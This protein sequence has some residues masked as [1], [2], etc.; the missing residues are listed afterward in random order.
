MSSNERYKIYQ[1]KSIDEVKRLF[2][3]PEASQDKWLFL[4][5][6][7]QSG[8][9]IS[10]E[11]LMQMYMSGDTYGDQKRVSLL[12]LLPAS[13]TMY[14]GYIS[15]PATDIPYLKSLVRS[16]MASVQRSQQGNGFPV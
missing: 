7:G 14:H 9:G 10:L 5:V 8:N 1:I 3:F 2:P 15:V 11:A 12:I 6:G 4:S 13:M 16:T